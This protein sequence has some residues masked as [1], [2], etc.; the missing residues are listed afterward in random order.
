MSDAALSLSAFTTTPLAPTLVTAAGQPPGFPA[1]GT[2]PGPTLSIIIPAY[3]EGKRLGPTLERMRSY[4]AASPSGIGLGDVEII[5]VDD[6]SIDDTAKI[7]AEY[8]RGMKCL[9][10]L[11][12]GVN[13][14]KGYSV[15]HGIREA[16][17]V[18]ALFTDADLSL[19]IEEATK[20][21]T[22][23][24]A[25]SDIAI[26][27]RGIDRSLMETPP[28]ALRK[29]AGAAFNG[30]VRLVVGLPFHDTQC[31]LKAFR[32]D[33]C[34]NIFEQQRIERFGF[35]P[36]ILFL[37][38]RKGLK[39]TEIPVRSSHD[40]GSKVRLVRDSLRMFGDLLYIRWNWLSRQYPHSSSPSEL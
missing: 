16:Q 19:P 7:V 15:K 34:K 20:L 25:G 14:G 24:A 8:A 21:L 33:R 9:R 1:K 4:F 35:D 30:L 37:A 26:G 22:A 29:L 39:T 18:V 32:R 28:P 10:L 17:G 13:R 23:I 36:E 27:S 11:S 38:Q 3:N 6:G 31:G 12:N 40:P 5:V 2:E